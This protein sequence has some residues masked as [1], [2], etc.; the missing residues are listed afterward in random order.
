MFRRGRRWVGKYRHKTCP[1]YSDPRVERRRSFITSI[2]CIYR[3]ALLYDEHHALAVSRSRVP[4]SARYDKQLSCV[5]P[6]IAVFEMNRHRAVQ[7]KEQLIGL[8]MLVPYEIPFDLNELDLMIIEFC[9][10]FG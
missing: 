3:A 4:C 8:I 2:S 10:N 9:D 1:A 7:H 6:N 5:K